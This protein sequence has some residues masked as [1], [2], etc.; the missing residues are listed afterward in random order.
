[1]P[2]ALPLLLLVLS[3]T[4]A[5]T[6]SSEYVQ[7]GE[8]GACQDGSMKQPNYVYAVD[9]SN[10]YRSYDSV[11][12]CKPEC[13]TRTECVAIEFVISGI[14]AGHCYL[15]GT[16]FTSQNAG[17]GWGWAGGDDGATD[18][19]SR[20]NAND[21]EIQCFV[22]C[23]SSSSELCAATTTIAPTEYRTVGQGMCAYNGKS[24]TH[25]QK[26]ASE[27]DCKTECSDRVECVAFTI[28]SPSGVWGSNSFCSL[29]GTELDTESLEAQ[30]WE[31]EDGSPDDYGYEVDVVDTNVINGVNAFS[32]SMARCFEKQNPPPATTTNAVVAPPA[33][34]VPVQEPPAASA[35]APQSE[36]TAPSSSSGW[37][38]T[39]TALTASGAAMAITIAAGGVYNRKKIG[40]FIAQVPKLLS[41]LSGRGREYVEL[42]PIDDLM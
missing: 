37:S 15:I 8:N 42:R 40:E 12:D 27:A 30:N 1:M 4:T 23:S 39:D 21:P 29:H 38:G 18:A 10:N 3:A 32:S 2:R 26:K 28:N 11:S 17:V 5:S 6:T 41:K 13:N 25:Y 19:I 24:L 20:V 9:E 33:A 22:R 7:F 36:S 16:A 35:A 14:Y 34:N 31:H